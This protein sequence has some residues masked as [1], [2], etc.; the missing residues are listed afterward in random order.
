MVEGGEVSHEEIARLH[1]EE[2]AR[3]NAE[4]E[5]A[6]ASFRMQTPLQTALAKARF[7]LFWTSYW[8]RELLATVLV[9]LICW[10]FKKDSRLVSQK[11]WRLFGI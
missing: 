8:P 6:M 9:R 3:A 5:A 2:V 10:L 1:A 4:V 11:L 7:Y